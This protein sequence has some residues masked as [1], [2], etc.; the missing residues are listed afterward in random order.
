MSLRERFLEFDDSLASHGVPPLTDWW[1]AG[2]GR[3]LDAYERDHVLRLVACVGRGAAKSTA[4][5]KLAA[6]FT[7]FGDFAIPIGERHF[8][9]VLS[10]LKEEATKGISII[11]RWL[12]LLG[13]PHHVA[14]DVIELD[15][16]PRGIRVVAAS[17]A[18][19][20]GWRAYFVGKD[21]RSKWPFGG[22]DD[23][24]AEE[25]DTSA[26]AMTA[27]H[28]NA[29]E[30]SFGSAWGDFGAFYTDVMSGDND[31]KIVLGPAP[32]WEAAPHIS[33]IACR[34]K[35][36]DSRRFA[37][38]YAC[39]FQGGATSALDAVQVR[40][41]LRPF[42][43]GKPLGQVIMAVDWSQGRG[44]SRARLFAQF[45]QPELDDRDKYEHEDI[46]SGAYVLKLGPNG[47]PIRK[48]PPAPKPELHI[49]GISALEGRWADRGVTS[50][51]IVSDDAYEANRKGA[52]LVYG[53]DYMALV[54]QSAYAKYRLAY[55]PQKWTVESK[56][57]AL[58]QV[59]DWIA[60][61]AL[62]I[63]QTSEGHA[64][65]DEMIR[66]SEI[67]R[68]SGGISIGARTGHD[69]R[70]ACLANVALAQ[71]ALMLPGSPIRQDRRLRI[72]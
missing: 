69:D 3:W 38:E 6:F 61:G 53:D 46:E 45:W 41:C 24:D 39:V 62:V 57:D 7:I 44:D 51:Q 58:L 27:T 55:T 31:T 47:V 40:A 13:V 67:I 21:E 8:A 72:L 50:D 2:I 70:W 30:V 1:R 28:P 71:A 65:A 66:L 19:S 48:N 33:E 60:N 59:R 4:L 17:V 26:G 63:E 12:T 32:T 18:A 25:I 14:G 9:I 20:S 23:Q 49:F 22:V 11:A 54:L 34:R 56:A 29:P 37:R 10:R 42:R 64:L 36:R 35:E 5:Y 68:P 52:S 43:Q 15:G 16:M